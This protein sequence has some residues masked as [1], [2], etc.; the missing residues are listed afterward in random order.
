MWLVITN[1]NGVI[2]WNQTYGGIRNDEAYAMVQTIDG[3][4]ALA[5]YTES[6][7]TVTCDMWLVIIDANSL[8]LTGKTPWLITPSLATCVA[9]LVLIIWHKRK[10]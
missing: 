4:F 6:F 8:G 7:G 5:G 3:N 1:A 2:T 10:K 9:A